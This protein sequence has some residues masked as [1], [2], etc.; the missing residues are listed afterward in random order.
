MTPIYLALIILVEQLRLSSNNL[1][2]VG[3]IHI[4]V[5]NC[6]INQGM[7]FLRRPQMPWVVY[8]CYLWPL[9]LQSTG[10]GSFTWKLSRAPRV[11]AEER[12]NCWP[13]PPQE[14]LKHSKAGLAQ[15]LMGVT[16]PFPESW[17]AERFIC[18]L[19]TSLVGMR[20]DYKCN[21]APPTILLEL[22][23]YLWTWGIFFWWDPTFSCWWLFS[24]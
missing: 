21:C 18:T 13:V 14:T 23:L 16:A 2:S 9:I 7:G 20:F 8:C 11:K 5:V 10:P 1:I 4:P 15:T 24:S 17:C 12:K 6:Q 3:P 22:L 19:Q